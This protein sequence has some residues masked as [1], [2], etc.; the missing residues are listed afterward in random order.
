MY[1]LMLCDEFDAAEAHRIGLV[2]LVAVRN[3]VGPQIHR[4]D[5]HRFTLERT[6]RLGIRLGETTAD[7]RFSLKE[8]ECL[9]ACVGAP[10]CQIGRK[11]FE[12][13]TPERIDAILEGL[14]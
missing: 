6:N 7:G 8:V 13:L 10:M 5:H 9:A 2:Q 4:P 14:A 1:H 11:Y 12:N 3:L